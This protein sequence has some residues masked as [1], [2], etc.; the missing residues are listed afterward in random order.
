MRMTIF[1]ITSRKDR[2]DK[3]KSSQD[4][5]IY[6]LTKLNDIKE[7][8]IQVRKF[9]SLSVSHLQK[10]DRPFDQPTIQTG[11]DQLYSDNLHTECI[12]WLQSFQ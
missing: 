8:D 10:R 2:K 11:I 7:M 1:M 12:D 4:K 5:Q 9:P 3:E 6:S